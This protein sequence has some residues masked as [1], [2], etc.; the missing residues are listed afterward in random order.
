MKYQLKLPQITDKD[1]RLK[2][3]NNNQHK[4]SD[5]LYLEKL[6]FSSELR[7]S[8]LNFF[9]TNFRVVILMIILVSA[10]GIYSFFKLPRESN[11]EVKIP[12][13]VVITG[14]PGASPS[15]IE[16][17]VTKK[18]ETGIS[19]LKGIDKLTSR[20]ANSLS[21][22]TVQYDAK[23]NL[24]DSLRSL[25][26]EV[27]S[28]KS[29]LPDE[30]TEPVVKEISFDDQ[31]ILTLA[32]TGPFDG[33]TL[34]KY[35]EDIKDELEKIS[36]VREVTVSGGDETEFEVAYDPQ[37]L[38]VFNITTDQANQ[39]IKATNLAVPSGNF[40]GRK[41]NY[42][43]RSDA[44]FFDVKKLENIPI[45]HTEEGSIVYLKDIASVKDRAI[46]RTKLSRLSI[47]SGEPQEAITISILKKTGGSIIAVADQSK[48]TLDTMLKNYPKELKYDIVVDYSKF[49]REDFDQLVHDFFLTVILVFAIL[50]L[51]VGLKEAFVAGLA[52]PLVFFITFGVMDMTGITLNFLSMFSLLLS[53]GLLVDD[54]I[55]VVSATKQY[56]RTG[57]FTPE[58]AVLLVLN[59]FKVVLTT[60]TLTTVWAFL[61]LLSASGIIGS[62]IKSIPITVSVT[63]IA[64]LLVALMI[65]H[66]LAAILERVR[67]TPRTFFL[68]I[69]VLA[70]VFPGAVYF[71]SW[72]WIL[73]AL[74]AFAIILWMLKWFWRGGKAKL[75]ANREQ[76][77]KEWMDDDLIKQKLAGNGNGGSKDLAN[78]LIHGVLNFHLIIPYYDKY[79]RIVLSTAKTRWIT[80]GAALGL[81]I[82]AVLMPI[83][84]I[85]PTE[86]FPATDQNI[87][88]VDIEA[89][90]GLKLEDTDQITRKAEERLLSYQEISNFSTIVGNP[91]S[92]GR[93]ISS[94]G[95]SHLASIT[96]NLKDEKERKL[97]SY[98]LAIR[99]RQDLE[100]IKGA[101]FAVDTPSAGPP[102]G[103]AFEAR[104]LGDD[105]QTLDKV[106]RDLKPM[107]TSI[108]GVVNADISLKDSP[109]EYTF[110]LIPARMELYNLNA[111]Y[112]GSILRT[113]IS[114]TEVTKV[115]IEG[116]E[117][118]VMARFDKSKIPTLESIQNLQ[119]LNTR[120]Q[121][122]FIKDVA[123]IELKPSVESITRIDQT[124]AVLLSASVEGKTRPNAVL[125]EF[126]KKLEKYELP[127][128]YEIVYG[129][130]NEQNTESVLSIIRAM[131][132]AVLL[133]ISTLVIQFNSFRQA[134]IVLVTI[135]L[136][137]IGV[138]VGMAIFR[139]NLSFPGLVGIL[140]LFGIVVKNAIILIDKINLNL[141]SGI[142]FSEAIIDAGKSRLEAIFITSICT[143]IGIIPVTLSN[144]TWMAL[145]SAVIFGL[146][147]SSFFTL[148]IIPTLFMAFVKIKK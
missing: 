50:L 123:K 141:R 37:K 49:I 33:F 76:M 14:Y 42:P 119:I 94:G 80:L 35:A 107:L 102:S 5:Y 51:I 63:L 7:K 125:A 106:A 1:V 78:R 53:L 114:G 55:V 46:E 73:T 68:V 117:I 10:W 13:A 54:A 70:I 108:P 148:F 143:I 67:F 19:G 97:K 128:G 56:L 91:S 93:L 115:I 137:L 98:E 45:T 77:E 85:V 124:R 110:N 39:A 100:E 15:D 118:K 41:Y 65:N 109:A 142:E 48:A 127:K 23:E 28:L 95:S 8:W 30:A 105:L 18:M 126:Q 84:G 25:R 146:M 103:S 104:I 83:I 131:A 26:D 96:I 138:F 44:R 11:P 99:I 88:Y 16:E 130:E 31:P 79:L 47:K 32:I 75:K 57:K 147:L 27:N 140:A 74:A 122:V 120:K 20:S 92:G 12:Y 62:F 87:V 3:M 22:I 58:E 66:P 69:G 9:I 29:E 134:I 136:A 82:I 24:E 101:A 60:T 86:F 113:A 111:A 112:V 116:K 90:T 132:V 21:Q 17:L 135:P 81:F 59:D 6:Q 52:V 139:V 2:S 38:T 36:G 89:P 40:E 133:I 72:E 121:P 64:S 43:I 4:S 145:G 34:K 144:E 61:P 129:G 71:H